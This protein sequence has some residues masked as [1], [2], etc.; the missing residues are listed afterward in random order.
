MWNLGLRAGRDR[1]IDVLCLGAH[2]DDIEIGCGGTLLHLIENKA[3]RRVT[4][5]VL[6]SSELRE[7]EA[8]ASAQA[9]LAG[10]DH[11]SVTVKKFRDGFFPAHWA[12]IKEYFEELKTSVAPDLIFTHYRDDR[13]QDHRAVSDLTW[14]TFRNHFVL[15]YEIPKFDGD[16]GA[17]N[18]FVELADAVCRAKVDNLVRHFA[19]QAGRSWFAPELF[20]AILRLRG[21][22]SGSPSGYAEAFYGR[23]V[24]MAAADP[25]A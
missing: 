4:W 6:S 23:K 8:L 18:V 13:H 9:F 7:R 5:V 14:N 16:M 21:M 1:G 11:V 3:V 12:E 22:E 24:V 15:E 25:Q 2:C 10:V 20:M 17:P 19:S